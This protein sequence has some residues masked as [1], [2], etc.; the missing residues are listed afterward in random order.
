MKNTDIEYI[1]EILTY[2]EETIHR[3][4]SDKITIARKKLKTLSLLDVSGS[5]FVDEKTNNAHPP[6]YHNCPHCKKEYSVERYDN[7]CRRCGGKVH[8]VNNH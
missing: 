3:Q 7:Y 6:I 2:I 5:L 1:N 4:V 8:W